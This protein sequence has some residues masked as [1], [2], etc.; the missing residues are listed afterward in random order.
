MGAMGALPLGA[1][2]LGD[3]PMD[4]FADTLFSFESRDHSMK[5]IQ[6]DLQTQLS[7]TEVVLTLNHPW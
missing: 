3:P 4:R 5:W 6:F 2:P 7:V 1:F